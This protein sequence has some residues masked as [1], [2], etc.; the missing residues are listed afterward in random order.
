MVKSTIARTQAQNREDALNKLKAKLLAIAQD[1]ALKDLQQIKG[2]QVEATFGQQIR[3]YVFAPY[4]LVKDLRT[5]Y[6]SSQV[7]DVMDGEIDDFISAYLKHM[8]ARKKT[9]T[10]TS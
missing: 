2:D 3:N 5:G 6:E 7:Q 9:I 8:A 1:Q 10:T 4:K